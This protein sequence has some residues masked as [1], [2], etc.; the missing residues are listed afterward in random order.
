MRSRFLSVRFSSVIQV[1]SE[2][3][4]NVYVQPNLQSQEVIP[5]V[6]PKIVTK[7]RVLQYSLHPT[8]F[9]FALEH[10]QLRFHNLFSSTFQ[11]TVGQLSLS[12]LATW[13][14]F[15][16]VEK[17]V[18]EASDVGCSAV[19]VNL[20]FRQKILLDLV[21]S[22]YNTLNKMHILLKMFFIVF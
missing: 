13:H 9:Y 19:P 6:Q 11:D 4:K 12:N 18:P 10:S 16:S 22:S 14:E 5:P 15:I 1:S 8:P 7:V 21:S 17:M 2:G 3:L 20:T